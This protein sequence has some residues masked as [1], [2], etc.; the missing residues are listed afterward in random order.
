MKFG[1]ISE[2]YIKTIPKFSGEL[3]SNEILET[4]TKKAET[5]EIECFMFLRFHRKFKEY[6]EN[7]EQ[8]IFLKQASR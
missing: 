1:I 6:I 4:F 3:T 7:E 5:E 2:K 8:S